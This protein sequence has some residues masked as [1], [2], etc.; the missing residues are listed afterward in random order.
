MTSRFTGDYGLTPNEGNDFAVINLISQ[1]GDNPSNPKPAI[2]AIAVWLANRWNVYSLSDLQFLWHPDSE[3]CRDHTGYR[4]TSEGAELV[5]EYACLPVPGYF[6]AISKR[7]DWVTISTQFAQFDDGRA[8]YYLGFKPRDD[9][10][11]TFGMVWANPRSRGDL[12]P[13]VLP[14]LAIG[15]LAFDWSGTAGY[16]IL[17]L[18]DAVAGAALAGEIAATIGITATQVAQMVGSAA[19]GTVTSG[20]DPIKGIENAAAAYV[21][22]QAGNFVAGAVDSVAA[23]KIAAAAATAGALGKDVGQAILI[24]GAPLAAGAAAGTF[25]TGTTVDDYLFPGTSDSLGYDWSLFPGDIVV[26]PGDLGIFGTVTVDEDSLMRAG[27]DAAALV[28]DDLGILYNVAGQWVEIPADEYA[29][30]LYAAVGP[31]GGVEIRGPDDNVILTEQEVAGAAND[32]DLQTKTMQGLAAREGLTQPSGAPPAGRPAG[33]TQPAA[34]TTVSPVLDFAKVAESL[35][36]SLA[37]I[38]TVVRQVE[39]GTYG[40]VQNPYGSVSPYGTLRPQ[41]VGVPVRNADGSVTVNNGNGTQ[42]TTKPNGQVVTTRTSVAGFGSGTFGGI[43]TNTLLIA[44]AGLAALL[45]LRR[46]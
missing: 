41:A 28:P 43:S 12:R 29:A 33:L 31:N 14:L 16:A 36:R 39:N 30:Q 15:S 35:T 17:G 21:G 22:A 9:G 6:T 5:T 11:P 13:I 42:T 10:R 8:T 24:A 25:N 45:L 18:G 46:K 3:D 26:D 23:G 4:Y 38:I 19:I 37:S 40:R 7:K 2:E 32:A 1:M 34:T 44:G 20:G 27:L